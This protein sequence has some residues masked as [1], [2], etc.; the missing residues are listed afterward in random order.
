MSRSFVAWVVAALA[1]P[2]LALAALVGEQERRLAGA[3]ILTVPIRGYDPRDL[4]AG[5]YLYAQFDWDWERQPE[6]QSANS[7]AEGGACV[8]SDKPKPR[9]R[10]LPGWKAGDRV[11]ADCKLVI[12]GRGWPGTPARFIPANL[13]VGSMFRRS[14][15]TSWKGCR[16]SG[17]ARSPPNSPSAPMAARRSAHCASTAGPSVKDRETSYCPPSGCRQCSASQQ[18]FTSTATYSST[19]PSLRRCRRLGVTF[20][21]GDDGRAG[22][23]RAMLS[24]I[25]A[26]EQ[27]GR[28]RL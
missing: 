25:N 13:D 9:L 15:R 2:V 11:D 6:A 17:R 24:D 22:T 8:L 21:I 10:F 28:L 19:A 1:L 14:G 12:A 27:F 3:T 16:G 18:R 23:V 26:L 7:S 20:L 5:H 4:L